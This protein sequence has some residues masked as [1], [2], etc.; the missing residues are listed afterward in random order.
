MRSGDYIGLV[1]EFKNPGQTGKLSDVQREALDEH[2]LRGYKAVVID[3]YDEAIRT[4]SQYI[5][6]QYSV[7]V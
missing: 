2:L 7:S 1:V 3:S 5:P 4:V 6:G